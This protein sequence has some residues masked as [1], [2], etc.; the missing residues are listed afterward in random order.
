MEPDSESA[1]LD[2]ETD[3]D[4][5][6]D[7]LERKRKVEGRCSSTAVPPKKFHEPSTIEDGNLN[8]NDLY[9]TPFRLP[10]VFSR[11]RIKIT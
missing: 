10:V 3:T 7:R 11:C 4:T 1:Q 5:Q 6:E 2:T 9:L 8:M